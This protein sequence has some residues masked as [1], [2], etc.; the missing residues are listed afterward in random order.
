MRK[1]FNLITVLTLVTALGLPAFSQDAPKKEEKQDAYQFTNE[2]VLEH[3]AVKSQDRTSTCWCWST[4][5]MM[6]SEAMRQGHE[7]LDLSPMYSV[8]NAYMDKGENY[9][10]FQG[11]VNFPAGGACHDVMDQVRDHGVMPMA[12]F[13]GLKVDDKIHNHGEL[14][15]VLQ[16]MLDAVCKGRRPSPTPVW[17]EAYEAVLNAYLGTPPVNFT[18]KGKK[19]TPVEFQKYLGINPDDYIE[20]TSLAHHP[21][22]TQCVAEVP[23][24]WTLNDQYYNVPVDDLGRIMENSIRQGHTFV[25]GGDISNDFFVRNGGYAIVPEDE[26]EAKNPTEPVAEKV[27]T[28]EMREKLLDNYTTGDDHGMHVV[29]LAKDQK[30]NIY[31]YTKNSWGDK[32]KFD[33]YLYMSKAYVNL[34]ATAI[35]VHKNALPDDIKAKFGIR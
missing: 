15:A 33:G 3:T 17:K 6:E 26:K 14:H 23:D 21:F 4:T 16:A 12:D 11:V 1:W 9:V 8:R 22:Y 2:I 30:G 35:M 18:Y 7:A 13:T 27:I 5:S 25:F 31:F 19:Y 34:N 20:V 24:N 10:R 29:G 28:Q 32:G